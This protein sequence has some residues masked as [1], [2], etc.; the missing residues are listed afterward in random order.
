M[1]VDKFFLSTT[2]L[3]NIFRWRHGTQLRQRCVFVTAAALLPAAGTGNARGA[4]NRRLSTR[5][6]L[7]RCHVDHPARIVRKVLAT[8]DCVATEAS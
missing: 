4:G 3:L 6:L 5:L 1:L 7:L 8:G 2:Y